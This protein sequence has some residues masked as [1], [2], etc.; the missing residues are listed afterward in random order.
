MAV[1][2]NKRSLLIV[3]LQQVRIDNLYARPDVCHDGKIRF[4]YLNN[5]KPIYSRL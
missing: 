5:F 3:N 2:V 4:S 1:S